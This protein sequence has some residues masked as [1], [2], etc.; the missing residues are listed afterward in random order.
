MVQ[1]LVFLV[2]HL[3]LLFGQLVE[4]VAPLVHQIVVHWQEVEVLVEGVLV[5]LANR[6]NCEMVRLEHRVKETMVE[7]VPVMPVAVVVE[8]EERVEM[9][10]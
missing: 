9:L 4:V 8:Q 6:Q 10:I 2:Q 3:F 1:T 5:M 7:M